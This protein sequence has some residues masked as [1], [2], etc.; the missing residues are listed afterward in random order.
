MKR[1][2]RTILVLTVAVG[3][4]AGLAAPASAA[5]AASGVFVGNATV[6]PSTGA[7][8]YS[9]ISNQCGVPVGLCPGRPGTWSFTSNPSLSAGVAAST[10]STFGLGAIVADAVG[11]L[12]GAPDLE[13]LDDLNGTPP[14]G[15]GPSTF[16]P[17][18]GLSAGSDGSGDVVIDA[19]VGTDHA[20]SISEVGWV[21]SAGTLIVFT[22]N[23]TAGTESG[24]VAGLVS[25]VPPIRLPDGTQVIGSGSCLAGD[26]TQFT[27]VGTAT[28]A[29]A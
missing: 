6:T 4:F 14:L 24:Y 18:C 16:G 8:L 11:S 17:W 29:T 21:S 20:A 3:L 28:V 15:D 23:A 10:G 1:I 22:G 26:A 2:V 25:A 9:P 13:P 7:G 19:V 5:T 27:I 12:E